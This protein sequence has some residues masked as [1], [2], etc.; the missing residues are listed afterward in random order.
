MDEKN[1]H[2]NLW[3][4]TL[5]DFL[6]TNKIR[7]FLY[8]LSLSTT[9][10]GGGVEVE[11]PFLVV[12]ANL[13]CLCAQFLFVFLF[14]AVFQRL[15]QPGTPVHFSKI[16][17]IT[18]DG[19]ASAF[20]EKLEGQN[21]FPKAFLVRCVLAGPGPNV[22]V[23]AKFDLF[24]R[25]FVQI[26]GK[27][28]GF[29]VNSRMALVRSEVPCL[30]YGMI[31]RH[32]IDESSPLW[33]RSDFESLVAEDVSF[34]ITVNATER[35][36]MQ[37]VFGHCLY[38]VYDGDVIWDR[39]FE[40]IVQLDPV[41][42]RLQMDHT[43]LS[44]LQ[45]EKGQPEKVQSEKVQS[46]KVRR[47]KV[48]SEKVQS[49]KVQSGKAQSE[50]EQLL[51]RRTLNPVDKRDGGRGGGGGGEVERDGEGEGEGDGGDRE[52]RGGGGEG[53]LGEI[54]SGRL[55]VSLE[56]VSNSNQLYKRVRSNTLS[57]GM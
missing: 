42:N 32:V 26:P 52:G 33:G 24:L 28:S 50:K 29:V 6:G 30:R 27:Q 55:S 47:E 38:S 17:L 16:A 41:R 10:G 46:E 48:Q 23:S 19:L 11:S 54:S 31:L 49:E 57:P 12:I 8:S 13:N 45:P 18:S 44:S 53:G 35:A 3:T 15:A 9:L 5:E 7:V 14:G 21:S 40:D 20:S 34:S 51:A 43:K 25:R 22:L 4:E 36:S 37:P 39:Q 56:G 1:Y 2:P